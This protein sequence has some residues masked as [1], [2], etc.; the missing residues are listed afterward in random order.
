[1]SFYCIETNL[2]HKLSNVVIKL[3]IQCDKSSLKIRDSL[4]DLQIILHCK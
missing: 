2:S 3:K 1:M 4:F